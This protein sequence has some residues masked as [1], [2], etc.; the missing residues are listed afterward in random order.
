MFVHSVVTDNRRE[1]IKL[2][3]AADAAATMDE[4]SPV[5]NKLVTSGKKKDLM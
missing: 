3:V 4:N 2:L 1:H 5:I